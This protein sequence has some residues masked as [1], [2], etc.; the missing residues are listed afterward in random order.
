MRS[1]LILRSDI[2]LWV[3]LLKL[4]LWNP[5]LCRGLQ[6]HLCA[7]SIGS[8]KLP[9]HIFVPI[10]LPE[11]ISQT[12]AHCAGPDDLAEEP[13]LAPA[14]APV[15]AAT[16]DAGPNDSDTSDEFFCAAAQGTSGCI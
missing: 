15:P 8:H 11:D 3:S 9:A 14:S 5:L 6:R 16:A 7:A 1:S 13:P 12:S 4:S 2:T 10:S